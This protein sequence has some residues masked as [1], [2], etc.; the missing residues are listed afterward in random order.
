[1]EGDPVIACAPLIRSE[2]IVLT[3]YQLGEISMAQASPFEDTVITSTETA[4]G[5]DRTSVRY[6]V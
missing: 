2:N 3:Q 4:S 5:D 6:S 1:M